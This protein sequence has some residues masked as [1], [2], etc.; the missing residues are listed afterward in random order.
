MIDRRT[1]L[2]GATGL[3]AAA[4]V[5]GGLPGVV[6]LVTG[7]RPTGRASAPVAAGGALRVGYLPIT[8]AS[9][10]LVAHAQQRF[11]GVQAMRPVLF[12]SWESLAQA[13]VADEVDVV[14]LL[15]PFAVQLRWALGARVRMVAWNHTNGSA[16]TV[17]PGIGEI[18]DLAGRRVAIPFWWSIHNVML[19]RILRGA[20]LRAVVRED[21]SAEAGTVQLVVMSPADMLP[22]LSTGAVSGY[23][24]ADP[25]NA[26]AEIRKVG[27][28]A[29]FVGDA[30]RDH[31]CCVVM[32][33]Q[34]LIDEAPEAVQAVTDGVTS[35]QQWIGAHRKDTAGL[36]SADR[37]LPQPL[38]AITRALTYPQADHAATLRHP[39][40]A[41]ERIG[42]A[43]YP[44]P[45][46]TEALV[47]AMRETVVDGDRGFLDRI[48]AATAHAE[49]TDE[50]FVRRS[51]DA[52]GGPPAFG[53]PPSLTRTEEV[54]PV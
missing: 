33:R 4:V 15:M 26:A 52:L 14:H 11:T 42:F 2:R 40:W 17:G 6:D 18:G 51:I 10:L 34:D 50:R 25:F 39:D 30:W 16:L 28:I 36:L 38:P 19:Q 49:L 35:A 20:G 9:P 27:R 43:P 37:Y 12:R 22:A 23:I 8:D 45:S 54:S 13:F 53:L 3:G 31:A 46:Y 7:S 47:G 1:L 5:G 44:F 41:G 24:V 32:V 48:D 21:P 29:R